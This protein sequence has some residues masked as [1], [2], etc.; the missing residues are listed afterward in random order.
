MLVL[1]WPTAAAFPRQTGFLPMFLV[2]PDP[3]SIAHYV[4]QLLADR[5]RANPQIVLGLATGGTME[6]VYARFIELAT[7]NQLDVSQ[8]RSFNLDEY[9]GLPADHPQSY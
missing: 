3:R 8:V 2:F 4:S 5:I 9:V 7:E 6:P 1:R